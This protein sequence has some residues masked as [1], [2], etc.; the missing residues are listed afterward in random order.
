M[1]CGDEGRMIG[2]KKTRKERRMLGEEGE[3]KK[4]SE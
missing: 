4:G 3:S 2:V 1:V